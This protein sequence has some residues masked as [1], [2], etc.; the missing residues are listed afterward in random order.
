MR[1]VLPTPDFTLAWSHSI[2]HTR[3]VEHYVVDGDRIRLWRARIEGSGAGMEAGPGAHFDGS[4]WTWQPTLAPLPDVA[5]TLSPYTADYTLC[6]GARCRPLHDWARVDAGTT[7][8]VHVRAC[9]GKQGAA[10]ARAG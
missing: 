7:A 10:P 4:G 2:E 8:A 5:L 1:A 6:A 9:P 3:W